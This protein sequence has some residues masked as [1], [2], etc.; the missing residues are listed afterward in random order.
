VGSLVKF[1]KKLVSK[2]KELRE[3]LNLPQQELARL[4][5][6]SRQT[7]YYLEKGIYNPSITLSFKLSEI[8]DKKIE[9]IFYLEPVIKKVI[10]NVTVG[11]LKQIANDIGI[12]YNRIMQLSEMTDEQLTQLFN[13]AELRKIAKVL[14]Q[15]FGE[16][17]EED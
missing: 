16:L 3:T 6:V 4:A 10:E 17:F 7:I 15:D 1:K 5:N 2:V 11:E 12:D 13:I 8:F 9:E 14:G